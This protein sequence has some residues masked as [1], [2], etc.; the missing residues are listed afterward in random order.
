MTPDHTHAERLQNLFIR[1]LFCDATFDRY[2]ADREGLIRD[3]GLEGSDIAHLPD[4][5]MSQLR[6]ERHGR[7]SGVRREVI[8]V[9]AQSFELI[10][11]LPGFD[12]QDFLCSDEFFGADSSLPHP[13]GTGPAYENASKFFFWARAHVDFDGAPNGAQARMMANGDFAAYLIGQ[14][15]QG[16]DAYFERFAGGIYWNESAAADLPI[17]LMTAQRHVYRIADTD[18]RAKALESGA[19]DLEQL[20]PEPP[21]DR[22]NIL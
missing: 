4:P 6:A 9:F 14:L 18:G 13:F 19:V 15:E 10:E 12:F 5:D 2:C 17:I 21:R 11:A 16:S 1:L 8:K 22:G 7:K 20:Q 3:S